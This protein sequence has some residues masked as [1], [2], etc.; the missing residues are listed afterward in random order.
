MGWLALALGLVVFSTH[1]HVVWTAAP[2]LYSV[3]SVPARPVAIV[4]GASVY[5]NGRPSPMLA[6]RLHATAALYRAGKV[7]KIIVSGA[8]ESAYYD[9]V[10][11]MAD[12][13]ENLGVAARDL[14]LDPFGLRTLDSIYRAQREFGVRAAIVISN[15]FHVP[16]AVFL[17]RS[18]GMDL[19]GVTAQPQR[20]HGARSLLRQAARETAAR[21]LAWLDVFVLATEPQTTGPAV[22]LS[23]DG[24]QQLNPA[25]GR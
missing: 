5:S 6:D 24:R 22:D 12:T 10:K 9:E 11:V 15:P 1:E 20:N 4:L 23:V 8:R 21:V 3:T 2:H 19:I 16:R 18:R 7:Q 14:Y 13:L 25:G 17:G